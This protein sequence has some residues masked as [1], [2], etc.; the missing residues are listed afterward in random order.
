MTDQIR[1]RKQRYSSVKEPEKIS[2]SRALKATVLT[3]LSITLLLLWV[4][5]AIWAIKAIIYN[6]FGRILDNLVFGVGTLIA[7]GGLSLRFLRYLNQVWLDTEIDD[8]HKK[9]L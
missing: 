4:Y 9:Y 1:N 3:S 6:R 2:T 5:H 7:N 8:D